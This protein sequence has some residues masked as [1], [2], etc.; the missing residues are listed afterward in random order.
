MGIHDQQGQGL[1]VSH[2]CQPAG[3][4]D[5]ADAVDVHLLTPSRLDHHHTD[6]VVNQGEDDELFEDP[7][8]RFALQD[9]EAH[10]GFQMREIGF[11]APPGIVELC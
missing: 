3:G 8:D 9:I 7:V 6:Q 4:I 2:R 10:G 1:V 5:K 11:N